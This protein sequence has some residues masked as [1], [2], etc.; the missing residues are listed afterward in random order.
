M[1]WS[2]QLF[3][4]G[5][6]EVRVHVTFFLLLAWFGAVQ[7]LQSGP[8]AAVWAV[9]FILILF[10]CVV[11]HEFG[12]VFAA[13]HYG[14]RTPT[15]TL[16]P[17]GGV[18]SMERMPEKPA[19]EVVVALAG[20]MVN[21]VIVLL[22]LP[23]VSASL[24]PNNLDFLQDPGRNILSRVAMA[25]VV[26]IVFNLVPA[27]PMDGGR[28]LRALLAMRFGFVR[29]TRIAATIGQAFA[30]FL[31]FI[32]LFGNPLLVLIAVF[33]YMAATA[34]SQFVEMRSL[35][36]GYL[37]R[38]AMITRFEKL[39][40][41]STA[42]DAAALL[43]RTTQQEFPVLDDSARL[44]GIVT[45]DGLIQTLQDRGGDTLVS[46]FME[47]GI[48]SVT[49]SACL[50]NVIHTMQEKRA[51]A[52]AVADADQRLIGFITPENFAEVMMVGRAR[53]R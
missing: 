15:I 30:I 32:G 22:L 7:W 41:T 31:G 19:Q 24:D 2:F 1:T 49:G 48:P 46:E 21:V 52:V 14:I 13:R 34:E 23:F 51:H 40:P 43:L 11:M 9:V 10:A 12:H 20:P 33:V 29:A 35:A 4:V 47:T 25:N 18:A 26:L 45:R 37:A 5:G 28:V 53:Q 3:S 44:K 50:D 8:Q 42:D 27:F 36:R 17:I 6:T 39:S 16:L 38:D